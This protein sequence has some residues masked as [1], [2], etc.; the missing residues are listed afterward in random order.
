LHHEHEEK[1]LTHG[2]SKRRGSCVGQM[3]AQAAADKDSKMSD[4][5]AKA[6]K[7]ARPSKEHHDDHHGG[8]K[9]KRRG[10][11]FGWFAHHGDDHHDHD[12]GHHK[13]RRNSV[14]NAAHAVADFFTGKHH[15]HHDE[16]AKPDSPTSPAARRG[17]VAGRRKS[18]TAQIQDL[19]KLHTAH[20]DEHGEHAHGHRDRG[21]RSRHHDVDDVNDDEHKPLLKDRKAEHHD[22]Y[23]RHT[24]V[25]DAQFL[26][27]ADFRVPLTPHQVEHYTLIFELNRDQSDDTLVRD[28]LKVH[29]LAHFM[30]SLGF[31]VP[32]D[33]LVHM[34]EDLHISVKE[35]ALELNAF[36][37]FMRR[38]LVAD[39]PSAKI[40][41]IHFLFAAEAAKNDKE[42]EE[43]AASPDSSTRRKARASKEKMEEVKT[44]NPRPS[45]EEQA[46][47]D[48]RAPPPMVAKP[49]EV[50]LVKK[51]Q[52]AFMLEK[53]GFMLDEL[54]INDSFAQVD[55]DHDGA[56][57]E[58]EFI[59]QLGI[60]K[61]NLL[62]IHQLERSFTAF[63]TAAKEKAAKKE[64]SKNI[65]MAVEKS[66]SS[67]SDKLSSL[68]VFKKKVTDSILDY[69]ND[70][71]KND[72][73][74]YASDLVAAL[75]VT[76]EEA[77]EM[78]FVA[79]LKENQSIDF[80]EFKQVVV[81]WSS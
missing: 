7:D 61:R 66:K 1:K 8:A 36:I 50:K 40:P 64:E 3:A 13:G 57:T 12:H 10:S 35:G 63:R 54:T 37:E 45:K 23:L 33:D 53:L 58:A 20:H 77:E 2:G 41:T 26:R 68:P 80:T 60:L 18:I 19:V 11:T 71:E 15:D 72:D 49:R 39:L 69:E 79:D 81:N 51:A 4:M 34:V 24:E 38:T 78:I 32:E 30:E 42:E 14:T 5:I 52:A 22:H 21:H 27:E 29:D 31:P 46:D 76:E 16:H 59:C 44:R 75:G 48:Q 28:R 43:A 70:T 74:L 55:G 73:H 65:A 62:E 25:V 9:A 67:L 56:I 17:S 6:N 47:I